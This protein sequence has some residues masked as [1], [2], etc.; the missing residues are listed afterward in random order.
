MGP[1]CYPPEP[2]EVDVPSVLDADA[3][4]LPLPAVALEPDDDVLALAFPAVAFAPEGPAEA[5]APPDPEESLELD[6]PCV[7]GEE[8]TVS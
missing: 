8:L 5:E 3:C 7:S 2:D 1:G 6:E 4:S